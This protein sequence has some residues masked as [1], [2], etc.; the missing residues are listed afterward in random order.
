MNLIYRNYYGACYRVY[1]APNPKCAVQMIVDT[2]GIFMAKDD[3]KHLLNIV[4][5]KP[6]PC[7]CHECGG[8]ICDRIWCPGSLVDFCLKV[9]PQ[10]L[11]LLE[12]LIRGTLFI[13]EMDKTLDEHRIK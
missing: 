13:M 6:A 4:L 2:V 10:A 11:R 5:Q 7:N 12:D 1:N 3:L 8:E 9:D